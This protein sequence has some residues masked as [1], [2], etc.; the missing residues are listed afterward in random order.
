MDGYHDDID[1]KTLENEHPCVLAYKDKYTKILFMNLKEGTKIEIPVTS[2]SKTVKIVQ[3]LGLVIRDD[4]V[5]LNAGTIFTINPW[6]TASINII[7]DMKIHI[8]SRLEETLSEDGSPPKN[9]DSSIWGELPSELHDEIHFQGDVKDYISRCLLNKTH[10]QKCMRPNHWFSYMARD[11]ISMEDAY[12]IIKFASQ[13]ADE[14]PELLTGV[15]EKFMIVFSEEIKDVKNFVPMGKAGRAKS[16]SPSKNLKV[17]DSYRKILFN[18]SRLLTSKLITMVSMTYTEEKYGFIVDILES[19]LYKK[20]K[21][22]YTL[23]DNFGGAKS[24]EKTIK[25]EFLKDFVSNIKI[26][27]NPLNDDILNLA[28]T[29]Q[30]LDR[31]EDDDPDEAYF[32]FATPLRRYINNNFKEEDR[33]DAAAF[34]FSRIEDEDERNDMIKIRLM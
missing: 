10:L 23:N 22:L 16:T 31:P 13:Y 3:G 27:Y 7:K 29:Y 19:D 25:M 11:R 32:S 24:D 14:Y 33:N 5:A 34:F 4:I 9:R 8:I 28:K 17:L 2:G 21:N 18:I 20:Y 26:E 1:A 6:K 15:L 30:E 12:Y